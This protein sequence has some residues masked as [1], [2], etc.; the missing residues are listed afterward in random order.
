MATDKVLVPYNFTGNDEKAIDFVIDRYGPSMDAEVTLF[1]THVPLPDIEISD[2]TVM[3]RV[4]ANLSY[5]R[6]QIAERNEALVAAA[7]RLINAG[8]AKEK[9]NLIFKPRQ[10]EPA[11]EIVDQARKGRYSTIILNHHP[12]KVR[13]FFTTCIS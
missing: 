13:K 7:E 12:S 4:A 2:K 11:Q 1:H 5:L 6:Q 9:V 8:F 10:R 3:T